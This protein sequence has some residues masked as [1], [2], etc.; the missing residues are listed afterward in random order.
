MTDTPPTIADFFRAMQS[1]AAAEAQMSAIFA[2]DAVYIE[3]FSGAPTE[4]RGKEAIMETM[5][6]GWAHPLPDMTISTDRID[7]AGDEVVVAWTCS[8]PGLPGGEGRGVNRFTL[9]GGKI[10]R[11]ET[12]F[13]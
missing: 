11:L 4:H 9:R 12:R 13:A 10:T 3:P 7:V 1:G 5:R 2:D 8:S 6:A